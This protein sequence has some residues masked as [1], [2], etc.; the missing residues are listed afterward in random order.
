MD[1]SSSEGGQNGEIQT[2]HIRVSTL[3]IGSRSVQRDCSSGVRTA[4]NYVRIGDAICRMAFDSD[5]RFTWELEFLEGLEIALC[6]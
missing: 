4:G 3:Q 2:E 6:A 1:K 5:A